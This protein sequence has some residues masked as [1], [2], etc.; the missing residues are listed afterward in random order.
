VC[1]QSLKFVYIRSCSVNFRPF[2]EYWLTTYNKNFN[3]QMH[4]IRLHSFQKG[5][6]TQLI[7][8]RRTSSKVF[9]NILYC[10]SDTEEN[11]WF[12][13]SQ[14]PHCNGTSSCDIPA[15]Y[16]IA[17]IFWNV[18]PAVKKSKS[19]SWQRLLH[20]HARLVQKLDNASLRQHR[21]LQSTRPYLPD[22]QYDPPLKAY[23]YF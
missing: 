1:G 8:V 16:T 10:T 17:Y 20:V 23:I 3:V 7:H 15:S 21:P 11:G 5:F 13:R 9:Q 19:C 18:R 12:S 6:S 22:F 14:L 2:E 4:V